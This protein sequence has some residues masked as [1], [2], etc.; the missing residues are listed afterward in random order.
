MIPSLAPI[1]PIVESSMLSCY[2]SVCQ[3]YQTLAMPC[4]GPSQT[5]FTV[6]YKD[7]ALMPTSGYP[8]LPFS[9]GTVSMEMGLH[10]VLGSSTVRRG[11]Q[12]LPLCNW[13]IFRYRVWTFHLK[14]VSSPVLRAE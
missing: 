5:Y 12:D 10:D 2:P 3:T 14:G 13:P 7:S 8:T 9:A 4:L 11:L 6:T 1:P